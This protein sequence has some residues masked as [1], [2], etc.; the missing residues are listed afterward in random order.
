MTEQKWL[1]KYLENINGG[2]GCGKVC[3]FPLYGEIFARALT[4]SK[5]AELNHRLEPSSSTLDAE[6]SNVVKVE[7]GVSRLRSL[8]EHQNSSPS[9]IRVNAPAGIIDVKA[10]IISKTSNWTMKGRCQEESDYETPEKI[11]QRLSEERK[12]VGV[13]NPATTRWPAVSPVSTARSRLQ[14]V[15]T[16]MGPLGTRRRLL[17]AGEYQEKWKAAAL[18]MEETRGLSLSDV[19][20][21]QEREMGRGFRGPRNEHK[22]HLFSALSDVEEARRELSQFWSKME[23]P[24]LPLAELIAQ[25]ESTP[26]Q[27]DS[28]QIAITTSSRSLQNPIDKTLAG[29]TLA[30][31]LQ[32]Q[33]T[34]NAVTCQGG[35]DAAT[36]DSN[37][38]V[39]FST[40][41]QILPKGVSEMAKDAMQKTPCYAGQPTRSRLTQRTHVHRYADPING[42]QDKRFAVLL[43]DDVINRKYYGPINDLNALVNSSTV[44][45]VR[46]A[47]ATPPDQSKNSHSTDAPPAVKMYLKEEISN[48]DKSSDDIS[49]QLPHP[50]ESGTWCPVSKERIPNLDDEISQADHSISTLHRRQEEEEDVTNPIHLSLI[51]APQVQIPVN[52]GAAAYRQDREKTPPSSCGDPPSD[53]GIWGGTPAGGGATVTAA[54]NRSS[55]DSTI[56]SYPWDLPPP[57]VAQVASDEATSEANSPTSSYVNQSI[58]RARWATLHHHVTGSRDAVLAAVETT[59]TSPVLPVTTTTITTTATDAAEAATTT[60]LGSKSSLSLSLDERSMHD[61]LLMSFGMEESVVSRTPTATAVGGSSEIQGPLYTSASSELESPRSGSVAS[62]DKEECIGILMPAKALQR[63]IQTAEEEPCNL[64]A[65][66]TLRKVNIFSQIPVN[67]FDERRDSQYAVPKLMPKAGP[68]ELIIHET[69]HIPDRPCEVS[70]V[71]HEPL[72]TLHEEMNAGIGKVILGKMKLWKMNMGNAQQQQQQRQVSNEYEASDVDLYEE[73]EVATPR[74]ETSV[75]PGT[76]AALGGVISSPARRPD[77]IWLLPDIPFLSEDVGGL[78]EMEKADMVRSFPL[79]PTPEEQNVNRSGHHIRDFVHAL[80]NDG[81]CAFSKQVLTFIDCTKQRG[82]C[83]PHLTM[84]GV[85]Q[86]M[87]GL[88]NYLQNNPLDGI[89]VAL[90]AEREELRGLNYLSVGKELEKV[91]QELIL[92]PLHHH[93]LQEIMEYLIREKTARSAAYFSEHVLKEYDRLCSPDEQELVKSHL[94]DLVV[95]LFNDTQ[96]T[97]RPE[98][99]ITSLTKILKMIDEFVQQPQAN[100]PHK[101]LLYAVVLALSHLLVTST[102]TE[103][104]SPIDVQRQYIEG[105]LSRRYL[106]ASIEG[107]RCLTDLSCTLR[108]TEPML[109]SALIIADAV[110][111][112]KNAAI[113]REHSAFDSNQRRRGQSL[114][115]ELIRTTFSPISSKMVKSYTEKCPS[116]SRGSV[117][118]RTATAVIDLLED[119]ETLVLVIA[120]DEEVSQ[121]KLHD[122]PMR[123]SLTVRELC[124][125]LAQRMNIFDPKE[126]GLFLH[127]EDDGEYVNLGT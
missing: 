114:Q 91:I 76:K 100:A 17:P 119:L 69:T 25:R 32:K 121:F 23:R 7:G 49:L 1:S 4:R 40:T 5:S 125:L 79:P 108:C 84:Q 27:K 34:E 58:D 55:Q 50:D 41:D 52:C 51:A 107:C 16:E 97:F 106:Q 98:K 21:T 61:G 116:P 124:N 26:T 65:C 68:H 60:A 93:L 90:K 122:F 9:P 44:H 73:I 29:E 111:A 59:I 113:T 117:T 12:P 36:A 3:I 82:Y 66:Q 85:R 72:K 83:S 57:L 74:G 38:P 15:I 127:V 63:S 18:N 99:K 104:L 120:V 87:S 19:E 77:K 94:L 80:A 28:S 89:D 102:T 78:H 62:Y 71:E 53:S 115:P 70:F 31:F 118:G 45:E 67:Q 14:A 33:I 64:T 13:D 30:T 35:R 105:L 86:F 92:R 112:L 103:T 11:L 95:R 22:G 37:G 42:I 96:R 43:Q 48:S 81:E 10:S 126:F 6:A 56:F 47:D 8:F 109:P 39:I 75:G 46:S 24:R 20:G 88:I 110:L 54:S 101:Q 123:P 2:F